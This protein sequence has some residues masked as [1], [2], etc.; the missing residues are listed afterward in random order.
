MSASISARRSLADADLSFATCVR[1]ISSCMMRRR[2]RSRS[3]GKRVELDLERA[4][5]LVDQVDGLVGQEAVGDVAVAQPRGGDD[6]LV[7]DLHAVV[8]LVLLLEPAQDRDGVVEARLAH[9]DGLEPALERAVGLDV[10]AV[11]GERRRADHAELA[12]R[13]H[14]LEDV[15]RVDGTLGAAGADDGVELVDEQ[16]DASLGL[17]DLL[18][19]GLEALLELAA[20]RGARDERAHGDRHDAAVAEALRDVAGDDALGESLDDRGLARRRARR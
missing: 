10:L 8:D 14:R 6:R 15:A 5:R 3:V 1:S 4:R 7:G 16:D 11:L 13:E 9:V 12:A 17:L 19:D 2:S 18:E 20:V